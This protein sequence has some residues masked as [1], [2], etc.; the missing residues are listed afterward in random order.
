MINNV[1]IHS[2]NQ[3]GGSVLF[4]FQHTNGP[5]MVTPLKRTAKLFVVFEQVLHLLYLFFTSLSIILPGCAFFSC[6]ALRVLIAAHDTHGFRP[7][8]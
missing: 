7:L 1:K 3:L 8:E 6:W 5:H 2:K 4:R